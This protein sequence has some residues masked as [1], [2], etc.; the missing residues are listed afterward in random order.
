MIET[1]FTSLSDLNALYICP[2]CK[3]ATPRTRPTCIDCERP[4]PE[5]E[6]RELEKKPRVMWNPRIDKLPR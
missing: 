2:H 5:E 6:R 3:I 4:L 1:K